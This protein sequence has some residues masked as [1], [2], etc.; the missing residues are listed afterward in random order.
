[1]SA[2]KPERGFFESVPDLVPYCRVA[3]RAFH[4]VV[5]FCLVANAVRARSVSDVVVNAHRK[6]VRFLEHHAD[7]L[8]EF[9]YVRAG[10]K[11]VLAVVFDFAGY[12]NARYKVVH[13]VE[14]FQKCGFTAAG[15]SDKCGYAVFCYIY[16]DVFERLR[17][18]VPKTKVVDGY[19]I[20]HILLLFLKYLP[21]SA[22]ARLMISAKIISIA[23][24]ANATSN[25]PR[26]F[27]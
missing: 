15:W 19:D 13:S 25:L 2:R 24:I 1:M 22:A 23:A 14:R 26:S 6:R 7:V 11:N 17:V 18:S 8:A 20:A 5:K 9:V 27:A 4:D 10:G 3:E 12:A 21:T 16:I